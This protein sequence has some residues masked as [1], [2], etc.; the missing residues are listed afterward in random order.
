MNT[1]GTGRVQLTFNEEEER[2]PSWSPDG[3]RITY[4]CRIPDPFLQAQGRVSDFEICVM[5]ADGTGVVQLTDNHVGDLSST[6]SPDGTQI[7][8]GRA[9]LNQFFVMNADGTGVEQI[10]FPPGLNFIPNWGEVRTRV[11]DE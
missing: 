7:V 8:F 2:A 6:W 3:S 1:D 10:T 5:N 4:S 9:P 11:Q